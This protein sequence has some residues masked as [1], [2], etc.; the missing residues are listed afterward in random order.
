MFEI[1]NK[2]ITSFK[3]NESLVYEI[4]DFYKYPD[5]VVDFINST[6]ARFHKEGQKPTH[7]GFFFEDK[8][9]DFDMDELIEVYRFL[10]NICDQKPADIKSFRTNIFKFLVPGFDRHQDHYWWPHIDLGYTGLVYL[11]KDRY[12]GTNL[13]RSTD[14]CPNGN[15]HF[16][17]WISKNLFNVEFVLDAD[18]N[19]LVLFDGLNTPHSMAT[20]N[21]YFYDEYR[22][23]QVFFFE[24]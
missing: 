22:I 12:P 17:P 15:E 7:N 10:S 2:E 24:S 21:D 20:T 18:Y 9:H 5:K 13:Y 11:N 4:K 1:N 23:N 3:V 6:P 16:T 8:R 14:S 19:K